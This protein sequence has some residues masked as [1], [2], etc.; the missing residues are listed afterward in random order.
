MEL[1]VTTAEGEAV[2]RRSASNMVLRNGALL[3]ANLFS[4]KPG[5]QP[6]NRLQVGF[7]T[8]SGTTDL[9]LLTL[10]DPPVDL[11]A[12]RSPIAPED[13]RIDATEPGFVRVTVNAL[14]TPTIELK[15]VTEAGLLAGEE[16]YNQVMF[17]PLT[18]S[19]GMNIT[20]FWQVLFP[21]GH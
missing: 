5:T 4:G 3:I 9:K 16:L 11:V 13:F 1:V 6:V 8:E 15:D 14:F 20:F 18:L 12:L 2:V 7:A 19:A 17:E 21:F 10:P